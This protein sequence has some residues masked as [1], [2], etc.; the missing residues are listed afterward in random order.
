MSSIVGKNQGVYDNTKKYAVTN[1]TT[2]DFVSHWNGSPVIIKAGQTA[3]FEQHMANKVT[4]EMVDKIMIGNAKLDEIKM[5]TPYAR[6]PM[7]S[8]LGVPAA[9]KVWEDKI[10]REISV[11]EE[12]PEMQMM[13]AKMKEELLADMSQEKSVDAVSTP[14]S[15]FTNPGEFS[16]LGRQT[17]EAPKEPLKVETIQTPVVEE[18]PKKR[19]R[20]PKAS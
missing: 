4:D 6:S 8:S 10:V 11:N 1:I 2:E 9:R 3:S 18:A 19:G 5:G 13:R 15:P 16:E 17:T 12:S 14:G 7:G 20:K